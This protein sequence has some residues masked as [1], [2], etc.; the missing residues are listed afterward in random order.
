MERES[1]FESLGREKSQ[2]LVLDIIKMSNKHDCNSARPA[3]LIP[4]NRGCLNRYMWCY[5][6]FGTTICSVHNAQ[7]RLRDSLNSGEILE[8]IG[9][10]LGICYYCLR[11][12]DVLN[13]GICK[14]CQD[15]SPHGGL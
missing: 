15:E 3:T 2:K 12:A 10:R 14:E 11:P 7:E 6:N 8:D 4:L 9:E 1:V 5:Y 13:D